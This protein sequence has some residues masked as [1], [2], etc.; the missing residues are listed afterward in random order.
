MTSQAPDF[1]NR[2][3]FPLISHESSQSIIAY[4]EG[5]PI[6]VKRFLFDVF[7]VVSAMEGGDYVL[8]TCQ[9]RYR[10]AVG[11]AATIISSRISLMPSTLVPETLQALQD[12]APGYISI[13]DEDILRMTPE[14]ETEPENISSEIPMIEGDREIAWVF[15]S[16]STGVPVP[17]PK[18]WASLVCNVGIEAKRL[19]MMDGRSHTI[20]GTV[21]PQ[22]M[23]GFES[24]V[25]VALQSGC[26]FDAG[27][28]FYPTDICNAIDSVP[29]PRLLVTTPLHLNYLISSGLDIPE[30]DL[31][32]SATAPLSEKLAEETES[33]L[34][35]N[36]LEI[37]GCTE[38]GQLATRSPTQS[39]QWQL[40]DGIEFNEKDGQIWASG[41][42]VEKPVI[43]QDVLEIKDDTHFLLHG[44]SSD[45]IN[46]AGKRSSLAYLNHQLMTIPGI[47]DGT[48]FMPDEEED[49]KVVRLMLFVVAPD[50]DSV[51]LNDALRE[52]IDSAFMPRPV[53]FVDSLP[54][55]ATGKLPRN[56]LTHLAENLGR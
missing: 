37:Y 3:A 38:T 14:V 54:R 5:K 11:L 33:K 50:L 56:A 44:R 1:N 2:I 17:H 32:V 49:K 6:T 12:I 27:K 25:L 4:R 52:R 42:H 8:N 39:P 22:H 21:P 43:M 31:V 20:V 36:L 51:T 48:F 47:V 30:V 34:K 16:G 19:G 23:Y 55:N 7:R 15:T 28:P 29:R 35:A 18:T 26:A 53:I 45:I 40:F 24:T 10:F 9:D 13:D 46:I 41:G